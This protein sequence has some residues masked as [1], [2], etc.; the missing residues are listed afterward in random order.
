MALKS[1]ER[2]TKWVS[3]VFLT[4]VAILWMAPLLWIISTSFKPEGQAIQLPLRWIPETITL[5]NYRNVLGDTEQSPIFLWFGN[6]LFISTLH[7]LLVLIV[8]ALAAYAYAR[9]AFRGKEIIF[10]TLMA[11]MMIPTVMNFIPLY[12]IVDAI[13]WIDTPWAMIVPGLGGVLG[14]FLLRSFYEGIPRELEE[15]AR[16]DGASSL[17]IFVRIILPLSK[18]ALVTLALL[19]FLGNWNDFLWPLIVT[20]KVETRTLPVGLSILQGAYTTQYAKL[21]AGTVLSALPVLVLFL[22]SQRFF[23]KG[24]SMSGIKG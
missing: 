16:I 21:M 15:A 7:T 23:V 17:Q 1:E 18:P 10:W 3:F 24:V 13:H 19:T 9:M 11:T 22:F 20:N 14:I 5:E 8:D 4:V 12:A 2:T 6:S